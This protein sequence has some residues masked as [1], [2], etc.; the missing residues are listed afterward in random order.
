MTD[1]VHD[2]IIIGAGPAGLTA[3]IYAARYRLNTLV[4]GPDIGG[5]VTSAHLI[6]NW[7]GHKATGME[8]MDTFVQHVKDFNVPILTDDVKKIEKQDDL[9]IVHTGKDIV[10]GH[11]VILTMGTKR[12]KLDIPGEDKFSG[13]GVSHCAT[14]DA[15]F[16]K[17][18][19]V[20][21]VGGSDASAMA[22]QVLSQHAK[23]IKIIYRKAALRAEPARVKEIDDNPKIEC[24]FNSNVKEI[25][26]DKTLTGVKLDTGQ[27]LDIQGL[28]I[29]IGGT[30]ITAMAKELGIE[31]SDTNRI[32]VNADMST[33]VEGVFAA[34]DITTGSNE[35][36]QI[37]TAASE[38]AIAALSA[39]NLTRKKK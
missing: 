37:V 14:C 20:A 6:E 11:T 38:G 8:I 5:T 1:T 15:M 2:L 3:A 36:N 4:I 18:K 7:P 10:K 34:G 27:E 29:E 17:D 9:F 32:K 28:F 33:N 26:G 30:P 24:I 19:D 16:F 22:A 12:R 35:F 31:L 25:H 21:V 23:S 39:F 13:K